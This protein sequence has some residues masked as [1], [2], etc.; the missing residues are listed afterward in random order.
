[1]KLE[2]K[3][4]QVT[5]DN[6]SE[7][8]Q[9][10]CF[11]NPKHQFYYKKVDWLKEQFKN[12][13][14]IKLLYIEGEKR[15]AGFIEYVPGEHCWRPV[16][17]KGYMFIHCLWTNGKKYQRQGLGRI[18]LNEVEKDAR[19]ES[20]VAVV[21]SDESFMAKKEL[22][23]KSGYEVLSES[24]KEQLMVKKFREGLLPTI[25]DWKGELQKYRNLTIV[26]SK[27]CPWVARFIEE[28]KPIFEKEKLEPVI[29]EF[30][31]A[32][33]AQSAPSLYGAFN[34]IYNGRLLADR[35]ISTTRFLNIVKKEIKPQ[36]AVSVHRSRNS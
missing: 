26:Y 21:T 1:M 14:K 12:G 32:E 20:G 11:I 28:V 8:P 23:L 18:L 2:T 19:H 35:Y 24:G 4:V 7:H 31:S 34:L 36:G 13:L 9:A 27:Q 10:I 29:I 5:A 3:I 22:F 30:E 25:N 15:P 33:Q 6:I 16:S 17:A